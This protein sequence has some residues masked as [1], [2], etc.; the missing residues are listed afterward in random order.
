MSA[1]VGNALEQDGRYP[2]D[3]FSTNILGQLRRWGIRQ[4]LAGL[5]GDVA[6]TVRRIDAGLSLD[7]NVSSW[8]YWPGFRVN[9]PSD[10][11]IV[12]DRQ[13]GLAFNARRKKG[14]AVGFA[15]GSNRLIPT[16]Q[17][18]AFLKEQ[19][20]LRASVRASRESETNP[21]GPSPKQ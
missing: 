17:W 11:A 9:D 3:L 14:N 15:D 19:E 7:T 10:L 1:L 13:G 16:A 5:S 21:K 2:D 20:K 6:E 4:P 8:V 12:W 18:P